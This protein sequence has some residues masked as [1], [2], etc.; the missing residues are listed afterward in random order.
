MATNL[1]FFQAELDVRRFMYTKWLDILRSTPLFK[2]IEADALNEMLLCLNPEIR[3]YKKDEIIASAEDNINGIGI[4]VNGRASVVKETASGSS[5]I[6]DILEAGNIFGEI[7]AFS[8]DPRW[9]ASVFALE[10]CTVLFLEQRKIVGNCSRQCGAHNRLTVNMLSIISEKALMLNRKVEYLSIKS[11]RAKLSTFF[12]EQYKRHGKP[13]FVLNMNRNQL[14]EFLNVSRPSMSRELGRM[15]D[16][17]IIDFHMSTI[18]IRNLDL[19]KFYA[20]H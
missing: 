13:L 5:I 15:K 3:N 9:P 16:E 7:A 19:L 12:L 6:M 18:R 8:N 2:D 1:K 4:L 10:D 11:M 14:A 20:Q 17:G